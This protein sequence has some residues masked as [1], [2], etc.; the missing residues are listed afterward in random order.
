MKKVL[1]SSR[2]FSSGDLD[3]VRTLENSGFTVKFVDSKHDMAELKKELHDAVGWIAGTAPITAEMIALAPKLK[4]I[5]RYGVGIESV[6]LIA[7]SSAGITVTNTPGAN[8]LAVAELTI[9]LTLAALR[10]IVSSAVA[11]REGNWSVTRGI[12]LAGSTVGIIGF[13]RIGRI[14]SQKFTALD[15]QIWVSDPFIDPREITELKYLIKSPIEIAQGANVVSLNA[16]G[17]SAIIDEAWISIALPGQVIINS[18]RP[19]LV[20]ESAIADGLHSGK[21]FAYAADTL[22]GEKNSLDS[23]LLLPDIASKVIV[24]AHLGGQTKDA[25]DQ[26]GKMATE[27][28]IAVLEGKPALNRVN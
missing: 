28:L 15:C 8:S 19:E 17:S 6:D 14:V 13:G 1:V 24:S 16:P 10:G 22:Q 11:V 9:G 26:M 23:P 25:I 18:A 7:S 2:S 21:L 3:L 27:N 5:A 12:Q 4:V 20:D